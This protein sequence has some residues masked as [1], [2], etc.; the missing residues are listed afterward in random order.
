L[1][2]RKGKG[3]KREMG[4]PLNKRKS[5]EYLPKKKEKKEKKMCPNC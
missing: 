4:Y 2:K 5:E 3:K 1:K